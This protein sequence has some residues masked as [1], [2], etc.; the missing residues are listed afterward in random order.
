MSDGPWVRVASVSDVKPGQV[1]QVEVGQELVALANVDGEMLAVS[2]VCSHEYV[3]LHDGWVEGEEIECPQ[4]GSMF[5]LRTGAVKNLPATQPIPT[6]RVKVEGEDVF[7]HS[8]PQ[9]A[10]QEGSQQ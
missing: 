9:A 7:I 4:H 10:N 1:I 8:E 6:F 2:D 3:L 5:S